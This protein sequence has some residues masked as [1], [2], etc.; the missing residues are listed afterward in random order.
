LSVLAVSRM[1]QYMRDIKLSAKVVVI[2]LV[3]GALLTGCASQRLVQLDTPAHL[4]QV[5]KDRQ[6]LDTHSSLMAI[7]TLYLTLDQAVE[8]ALELNLDG[9]V[10]AL[11]TIIAHDNVTLAQLEAIPILK[12]SGTFTRRNNAAASSSES[13]LTGTQSLEPSTSSEKARRLF[14]LQ[15]Q[16]NILDSVIAY[17]DGKTADEQ[18][19]IAS[20]RVKKVRQNIQRDVFNA[21]WQAYAG[22]QAQVHTDQLLKD[23]QKFEKSIDV[24]DDERLLVLADV[25]G[26]ISDIQSQIQ[27]INEMKESLS[28]AELELKAITAVPLSQKVALVTRP[29][30]VKDK[31]KI[32]NDNDKIENLISVALQNRSEI[33]EEFLKHNQGVRQTQREIVKTFP[34]VNLI[35][36]QNYDSNKFLDTHTWSNFSSAITQSITS[37]ITFPSRYRASKNKQVL[38][39]VRRQALTAAIMAQV[40]IGQVRIAMAEENYKSVVIQAKQSKRQAYVEAVKK[41]LGATSGFAEFMARA[42]AVSQDVEKFQAYAQMQ[43]AYMDMMGTLGLSPFDGEVKI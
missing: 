11:E 1:G 24:A 26:R 17:L 6:A 35:Y 28:L 41:G 36:A 16:W 43:Q 31:F 19:R 34:G 27:K 18:E 7:D 32:S 4:S 40:H 22:Q 10:A 38:N 30:D 8:R 5:E 33:R 20:E 23:A 2:P 21:Y 14:D 42:G 39:E 25:S 3:C 15:A 9:H 29:I 12:A 37:F 13:I